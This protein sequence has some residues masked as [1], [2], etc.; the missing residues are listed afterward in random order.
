MNHWATNIPFLKVQKIN[1]SE[2]DHSK[3]DHGEMDHSK[4]DH[5]NSSPMGE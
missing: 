5:S 4:M 1:H 3:M 2:M